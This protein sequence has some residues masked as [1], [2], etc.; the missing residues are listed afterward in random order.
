MV[1]TTDYEKLLLLYKT[2]SHEDDISPIDP[3]RNIRFLFI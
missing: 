2:G 3:R 1:S